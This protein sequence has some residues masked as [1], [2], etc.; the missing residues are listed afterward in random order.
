MTII[1]VRNHELSPEAEL[2]EFQSKQADYEA[3]YRRTS[4]PLALHEAIMHVRAARQTPPDWL[5]TA[6]GDIVMRGRT[7]QAVERFKERMRHVRRYRCVRELRRSH[8]K[9]RAL[10]LA[11]EQL[12]ASGE[13]AAR[14]TIDGSYNMVSRDLKRS[15]RNSEYYYLNTRCEPTIVVC[16]PPRA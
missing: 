12:A 10:D 11:V 3:A 4:E 6:L 13:A 14:A 5:V 16:A 8:T 2:K 15:G 1:H 9:E 7:D